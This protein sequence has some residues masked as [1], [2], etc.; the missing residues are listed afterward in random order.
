MPVMPDTTA[1]PLPD[2]MTPTPAPSSDVTIRSPEPTPK[3]RPAPRWWVKVARTFVFAFSASFLAGAATL[4]DRIASGQHVQ[5]SVAASL[6][7][8][9][10]VG[11]IAAALRAVVALLPVFADDNDIGIKK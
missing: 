5:F 8:G 11:G 3:V 9:L 7:L 1:P 10:V 6:L 2:V 4:A